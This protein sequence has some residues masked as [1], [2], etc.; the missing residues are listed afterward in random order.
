M[1]ESHL[2]EAQFGKMAAGCQNFCCC[3]L[4]FVLSLL[5]NFHQEATL[6]HLNERKGR[7]GIYKSSETQSYCSLL[8]VIIKDSGLRRH[9]RTGRGAEG[10]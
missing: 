10:W 1:I 6:K 2:G 7:V 5:I 3:F 4:M 9:K 8:A